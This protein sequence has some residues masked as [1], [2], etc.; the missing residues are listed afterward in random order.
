MNTQYVAARCS[1]AGCF[2]AAES[3]AAGSNFK[4]YLLHSLSS[5]FPQGYT[6][7]TY[8]Q[9]VEDGRRFAANLPMEN[10]DRRLTC[11]RASRAFSPFPCLPSWQHA[12]RITLATL[13][14]L[15][16]LTQAQLPFSQRLTASFNKYTGQASTP[17]PTHHT[18]LG[19][20]A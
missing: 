15:W 6:Q 2:D 11:P 9:K 4:S 19:G 20:F 12:V 5:S 1:G 16:S 7:V 8:P 10:R 13:K 18:R 14:S 3:Q 17:V